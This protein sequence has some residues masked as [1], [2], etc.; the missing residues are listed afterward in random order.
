MN[1]VLKEDINSAIKRLFA[2]ELSA[3]WSATPYAY[4]KNDQS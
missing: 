1:A 3:G 4:L 2:K